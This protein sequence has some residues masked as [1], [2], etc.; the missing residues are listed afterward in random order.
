MAEILQLK[1]RAERCRRAGYSVPVVANA[2]EALELARRVAD[3]LATA[4]DREAL[5]SLA[6]LQDVE[7]VL[8]ERLDRLASD[9]HATRA[10]LE[11]IRGGIRA[12]N[13]YGAAAALAVHRP[14]DGGA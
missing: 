5:L 10:E 13:R 1:T 14:R 8:V 11:K 6:V 9:M 12:S 2:D 3:E 7:S 4:S